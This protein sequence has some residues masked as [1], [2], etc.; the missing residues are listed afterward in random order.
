MPTLDRSLIANLPPFRALSAEELDAVLALGRASRYPKGSEVFSQDAE[1]HA[2][3]LLLSGHV[4][5]VRTTPDGHQVVPRYI[6]EGELFGI[7]MAMGRTTYP[8]SAVAAVDCV[9]L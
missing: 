4:R 8:A 3:Y 6:N 7:A 2:F 5:V 1:A 9:I